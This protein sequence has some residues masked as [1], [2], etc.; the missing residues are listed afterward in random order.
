MEGGLID[1]SHHRGHAKS[2]LQETAEFSDAIDVAIRLT[3]D[4]ADDT[5]IIVTSDH[6]HS[7]VFTGY[8]E[9]TDGVLGNKFLI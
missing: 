7:L 6:G 3:E 4:F 2:A 8:P 1:Y 9:R 5:L